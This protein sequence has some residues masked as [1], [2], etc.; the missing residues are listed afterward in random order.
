[1]VEALLVLAG[2][3]LLALAGFGLPLLPAES[4]VAAGAACAALGL[5]LGLP[6]GLLYHLRLRAALRAR[7]ELPGR[8]W[9]RPVA[10][11]GRLRSAE[12][13]GVLAWFYA[14]GAGFGL[15]LLGCALVVAG[16]LLAGFRAGVFKG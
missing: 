10:L 5:L 14:G 9:L 3:A 4:L 13:R 2:V 15:A 16:V 12:R 8:W 7:G 11:H 1:V 6:T